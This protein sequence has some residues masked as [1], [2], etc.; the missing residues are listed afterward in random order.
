MAHIRINKQHYF[1][2][3][4]LIE[5]QL[6]GKDKIC[7]VLKDNA[8]GHGLEIMARLA[9]EFGVTKACVRNLEEAEAIASLH[10]MILALW[11]I[12][13]SPLTDNIHVA[14]NSLEDIP[15]MPTGT[16]VHLKLDTGMHRNGIIPDEL[17]Q[18]LESIKKNNLCLKG[19]FTHYRSADVLSSEFFWQRKIFGNLAEAI[20][21]FCTHQKWEKP[22]IHSA[23][24]PAAFRIKKFDEDFAR[25]GISIYGYLES[26]PSFDLPDLKPVMSLWANR[27][28][29]R[30]LG[31][32]NRVGYGGGSRLENGS[33]ISTYDIG[34]GDGFFRLNERQSYTTPSGK[35]LL[36][37]ASMDYV[38]VEGDADELCLFEDVRELAKLNN[39]ITYDVMV[40][41]SPKIPRIVV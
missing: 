9:K 10:P 40:K 23:N 2:N 31:Q 28:S 37:R 38:S 35:K 7:I 19:V 4:S 27:I 3:L 41:L 13:D 36:P 39:T 30:K 11:G 14:L 8:Y 12:P 24:S 17:H 6:G 34:Y 15:K 16:N 18:A 33:V 29:T 22:Q 25:T 26:P 32:G 20:I 5:R 1:H 21:D